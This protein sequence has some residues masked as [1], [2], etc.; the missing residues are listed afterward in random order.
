MTEVTKFRNCLRQ[1]AF[2]IWHCHNSFVSFYRSCE[3]WK[4]DINWSKY[5]YLTT[6]QLKTY[7]E[8]Y[9]ALKP[10]GFHTRK[11][12]AEHARD[13][14]AAMFD[15]DLDTSHIILSSGSCYSMFYSQFNLLFSNVPHKGW[16][17]IYTERNGKNAFYALHPQEGWLEYSVQQSF[18]F[19]SLNSAIENYLHYSLEE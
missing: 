2:P 11:Q 18:F 12:A 3:K 17:T 19:P 14:F 7:Q 8:V 6:Q 16:Q 5:T 10:L 4:W 13:F 15:F 1:T 9:P